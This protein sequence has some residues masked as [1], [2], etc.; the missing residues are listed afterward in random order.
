MYKQDHF[1]P[2][3]ET[4]GLRLAESREQLIEFINEALVAPENFTAKCDAILE[5]IITYKDG[6][7]TDRVLK[8]MDEIIKQS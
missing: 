4:G 2:I 8:V 6:K 3:I 1:I 5:E 7:C